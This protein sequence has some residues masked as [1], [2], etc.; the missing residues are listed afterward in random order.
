MNVGRHS[1]VQRT[2][3]VFLCLA[4]R[5]RNGSARGASS[6]LSSLCS[7]TKLGLFLLAMS[8]T[9]RRLFVRNTSK[10]KR[11]G[12]SRFCCRWFLRESQRKPAAAAS[13][14]LPGLRP[15]GWGKEREQFSVRHWLCFEQRRRALPEMKKQ[16]PRGGSRACVRTRRI[17]VG[18]V[19]GWEDAIRDARKKVTGWVVSCPAHERAVSLSAFLSATNF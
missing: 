18:P 1:C 13:C 10:L 3:V 15:V 14:P 2:A 5:N 6:A 11:K 17:S 4:H 16:Q 9:R 8:C 7:Q 12:S 19:V